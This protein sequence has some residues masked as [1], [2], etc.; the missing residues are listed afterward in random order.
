M[1]EGF[2]PGFSK[3]NSCVEEGWFPGENLFL[4]WWFGGQTRVINYLFGTNAFEEGG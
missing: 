3:A 4:Q 2:P 1:P